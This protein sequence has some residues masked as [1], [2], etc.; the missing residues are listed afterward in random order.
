MVE[1]CAI[2]SWKVDL[3]DTKI[4]HDWISPNSLDASS[5]AAVEWGRMINANRDLYEC[6]SAE[7]WCNWFCEPNSKWCRV[8]NVTEK[9]D[10]YICNKSE[11]WCSSTCDPVSKWCEKIN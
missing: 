11:K 5:D 7:K 3:F 6:L 9:W 10:V 2:Y 1:I 8:I 4:I